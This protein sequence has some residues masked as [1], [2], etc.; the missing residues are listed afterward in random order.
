VSPVLPSVILAR[1]SGVSPGPST[2]ASRTPLPVDEPGAPASD[3]GAPFRA[4]LDGRTV[5]L[6]DPN[7]LWLDGLSRTLEASGLHVVASVRASDE[8]LDATRSLDPSLLITDVELHGEAGDGLDVALRIRT[9]HPSTAL[10]VLTSTTEA[11]RAVQ[12]LATGARTGYL[13]KQRVT[14][15]ERFLGDVRQVL[16]GGLVVDPAVFNELVLRHQVGDPLD[17]LSPREREVLILLAEGHSNG[18]IAE[19]L[20]V[21]RD[22]V[23]KHIQNLFLKL[24]IPD[25]RRVHRRVLA[26]LVYH[27]IPA[28]SAE[29]DEDPAPWDGIP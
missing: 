26:T 9:A 10:I 25:D 29:P 19:R 21:T 16:G 28:P 2:R 6:A 17:P 23:E 4:S 22:T 15:V 3:T 14:S 24:G 20:S 1:E 7:P 11:G 8:A 18:H 27:R 5:V 12:L 13:L